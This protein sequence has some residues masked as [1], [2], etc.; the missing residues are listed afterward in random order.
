MFKYVFWPDY[1]LLESRINL[2]FFFVFPE[3]GTVPGTLA[4]T[5]ILFVW[6]KK[7]KHWQ[8]L[9]PW[10][11]IF[12]QHI[13]L[14]EGI[15]HCIFSSTI[16]C[17]HDQVLDPQHIACSPVLVTVD[18]T[19]MCCFRGQCHLRMWLWASP[20]RSGSTWTLLRGPCT[21]TWCWRTI[22]TSSQWVG[23]V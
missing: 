22:A 23:I 21:G 20:R 18:W 19:Q 3:I 2:L 8:V 15:L 4:G 16:N 6:I 14:T 12:P 9:I 5:P 7:L 11:L 1:K 17:E 13:V 10:F